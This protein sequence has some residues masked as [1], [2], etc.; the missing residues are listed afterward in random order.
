MAHMV[1][2]YASCPRERA[3]GQIEKEFEKNRKKFLTNSGRYANIK[4]LSDER[5]LAWR[6]TRTTKNSFKVLQKSFKKLEKSA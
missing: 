2:I 1:V 4:K 3:A 5:P 6:T